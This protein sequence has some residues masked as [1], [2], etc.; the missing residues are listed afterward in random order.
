M[1]NTYRALALLMIAF[2]SSSLHAA[3]AVVPPATDEVTEPTIRLLTSAFLDGGTIPKK[4][5]CMGE[6]GGVSPEFHWIDTPAGTVSFT[7]IFS[8]PDFHTN[9][10]A[11]DGMHWMLW[12]IP[13][14]ARSL[15]EAIPAT[16]S[17]EDGTRQFTNAKGESSYHGP[18]G[19]PGK[20]HHYTFGLYA[21]DKK[22]DLPANASRSDVMNAMDGH[23]I[24]K[25]VYIGMFSKEGKVGPSRQ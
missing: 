6:G 4:F 3:G 16:A 7:L 9:K 14:T 11:A 24:G 15:R 18:C 23:I 19:R 5:T 10:G 8:D 25:S 2:C 17:L 21:L 22:L 12:N 13:G 1:M 20:P